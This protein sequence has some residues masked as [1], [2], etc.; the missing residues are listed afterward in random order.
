MER[1]TRQV[2]GPAADEVLHALVERT[3]DQTNDAVA[4]LPPQARREGEDA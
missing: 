3:Q 2:T 4:A 1:L